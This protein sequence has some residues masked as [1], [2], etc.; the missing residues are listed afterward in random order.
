MAEACFNLP[1]HAT[2]IQ[3][4]EPGNYNDNMNTIQQRDE[5][6]SLSQ[7]DRDNSID[8]EEAKE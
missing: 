2:E 1:A 4:P 7:N 5:Q 3:P 6:D 8:N